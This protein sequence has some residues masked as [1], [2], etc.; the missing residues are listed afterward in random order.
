[1]KNRNTS[2]IPT[3]SHSYKIAQRGDKK[4]LTKPTLTAES[5]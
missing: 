5:L 3:F 1:M 4:R 2:F